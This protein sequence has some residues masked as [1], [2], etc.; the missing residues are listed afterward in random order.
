MALQLLY[1]E[2][3]TGKSEY[4][5]SQMMALFKEGVPTMML[6]PEQFAHSAE[7]RL[8]EK[9]GFISD[10]IQSVSF[11]RLAAKTLKKSGKLKKNISR[12]GK[13]MLLSK[14]ILKLSPSLTLY[15][16]AA[17]KPGFIDSML[18]FIAE[19]KRSDVSPE[20]LR[21]YL[22]E[23]NPYL[24][25]KLSELSAIYE[26]YQALLDTGYTDSEDF[27]PMLAEEIKAKKLFAG[28]HIFIDE[29]FRFTPAECD[30][31]EA[32]LTVGAQVCVTVCA[33]GQDAAGIFSPAVQTA[34]GLV[35]IAKEVGA[36]INPPILLTE[37]HRFVRSPELLHF[38]SEYHQYPPHIYKEETQ[39]IDLYIA[40]DLY[41]E[42]LVLAAEIRRRME[43][44]NLRYR[45]I[46]IICG[47]PDSYTDIIKTVFPLYDIPVFIDQKKSLL[48]HPIIIMLLSVLQLMTHGIDTEDL[49]N[50]AKTGYAGISRDEADLLENFA[51]AGRLKKNDWLVDERFLKRAGSVFY[52]TE[53]LEEHNAEEA[54]KLLSIRNRLLAPLLDLRKALAEDR[55]LSHR[56]E[57]L[58]RFFEGIGLYEQVNLEIAQLKELSEHRAALEYGE[59][60][61]LLM[62]LL[63]ELVIAL[64]DEKIGLI[65]LK[66]ILLSGLAQCEISTIPPVTDQVF[67][68][69]TGRSLV[70]NV[71]AL[72]ILGANAGTFPS[73]PPQEGLIKDAERLFLEQQGLSLGPDG[74]KIAFQNQFLVYSALTISSKTMHVSYPVSDLEGKGLLPSPLIER[75]QKLFPALKVTDNTCTP[76]TANLLIAGKKSAWQYVL[77]HFKDTDSLS[78]ALRKEI[79][80]DPD[81]QLAYKAMLRHSEY[82]H[83]VKDL[84]P[85]MA[86]SLYGT[87]LRGS[88][89]QLETYS[90]CPFSYFLRYG[91]KAKERKILKIDAP[92]IGHLIH[93]IVEIASRRI[94][95]NKQS[96]ASVTPEDIAQIAGETVDELLATLFISQLYSE[97]RLA[98]LIRKLKTQVTKMLGI[99]CEH[100]AQGEFEP[101]A[102]EL[103]FDEKGELPPVTVK[104]PTGESITLIGRI[105]RIDM[106]KKDADI[107][108][109]IID[110][111]TGHK[112]FRLSDV[113]HQL[114]LQLAVYLTAVTEGGENLFGESIKPAGMFYF[115]LVDKNV[116]ATSDDTEAALKKQF[117]MDGMV[118][119]DVD[120]IRAM[121]KGIKGHSSILPAYIR[122]DGTIS[123]SSGTYAT[124]EQFQ[125]L[126]KYIEKTIKKLGSEILQGSCGISPCRTG[127]SFPCEYCPYHPVCAFSAKTDPYRTA[128]TFPDDEIW[129]KLETE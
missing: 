129:A 50:Y 109:K 28:H 33:K 52:Q 8:I 96:F 54:E 53:S 18:T 86:H 38:E 24:Y 59:I 121:D 61:N 85:G 65:R 110:Y 29:F 114:S 16:N 60:Y 19:C 10:D 74:K 66:T 67:F 106:L 98:A 13:S 118:L 4:C 11:Q 90:K 101:C 21:S 100:V 30:V 108:I 73:A 117:K 6:V 93:E 7:L 72:F 68:G 46:A 14:A 41:T 36:V 76:P 22:P 17:E 2:A 45:D 47:N 70:K 115:R 102:F 27:L 89:T 40:P 1:G 113:Y 23:N 69:D 87:N 37:K 57:A 71:K 91:L 56:A 79:A 77:E 116:S 31:I 9:N 125:K 105:D 34:K 99:I 55:Q 32:L 20:M 48:T 120:I 12:I 122:Q 49:I 26:S 124:E 51:L 63:D 126:S 97:K 95:E 58:F 62:T 84:S 39:D 81:Y 112:T 119:K 5:L 15:Q 75:L 127:K 103:A 83:R 44:D 25:M 42:T 35:H 104:L 82:S 123:D 92:D 80:E 78:A 88:V 107:Y 3:G 43:K 64:G 128:K 94:T 111:K